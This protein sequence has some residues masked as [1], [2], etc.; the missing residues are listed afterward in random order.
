MVVVLNVLMLIMADNALYYL[1]EGRRS[2]SCVVGS[3]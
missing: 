2:V 3:F 1:V